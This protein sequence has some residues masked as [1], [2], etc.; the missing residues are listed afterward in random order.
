M[1]YAEF[2][3]ARDTTSSVT[4]VTCKYGEYP[5]LKDVIKNGIGGTVVSVDAGRPD[6]WKL[7]VECRVDVDA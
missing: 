7:T 2:A 6:A 4:Q 5:I 1:R 3:D